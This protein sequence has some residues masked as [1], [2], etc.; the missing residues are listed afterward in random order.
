[1]ST[2]KVL[3]AYEALAEGYGRLIDHKPHN[4][5]YDRPNT[6][7]LFPDVAGLSILDAGCGPGKYSEL[8]L[9]KGAK[10][11]GFDLSPRM[12]Q[13][14]KD[15]NGE[16]A[17]VFVHDM[18]APLTMFS[19]AS[20]DIVLCA[21]SLDY[22]RDW[23]PTLLEFA[24]VLEP[25]GLLILSVSHPFFDYG[26]FR[27]RDYFAVEE[28]SSVWKGFGRPVTVT[29]HRRSLGDCL[30]PITDCGF[31]IDRLL[32]PRPTPEFEQ[33]DPR[34]FHELNAFP[35]FLCIRASKRA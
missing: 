25:R 2:E 31:Q 7:S 14:A 28:V 29:S 32:E 21:L 35:S 11:T 23:R 4:A 24:R 20:F 15:R 26:Y 22:V 3:A 6:L 16:A 30:L 34:H 18:Q 5:F 13:A 19:D 1:M 10:V 12:V 17:H 27:S 33:A 9:A 8:L